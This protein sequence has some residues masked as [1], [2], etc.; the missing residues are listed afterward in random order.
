MQGLTIGQ[1]SLPRK[2]F[3][4]VRRYGSQAKRNRS[5]AFGYLPQ[6]RQLRP[7]TH[8]MYIGQHG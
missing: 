6:V 7:I 1:E 3:I 5:K 8:I 4:R 2:R